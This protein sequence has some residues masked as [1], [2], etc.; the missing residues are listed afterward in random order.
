MAKATKKATAVKKESKKV[1]PKAKKVSTK[2]ESTKKVESKELEP[3]VELKKVPDTKSEVKVKKSSSK[4]SMTP[5]KSTPVVD[6]TPDVPNIKE[7]FPA[8]FSKVE[9]IVKSLCWIDQLPMANFFQVLELPKSKTRGYQYSLVVSLAHSIVNLNILRCKEGEEM[10]YF[11]GGSVSYFEGEFHFQSDLIGKI[12]TSL[13]K[14]E[15]DKR[16]LEVLS[17]AP[18]KFYIS[19]SQELLKLA[20]MLE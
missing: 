14:N 5:K 17:T 2:K 3:A 1:E 6:S 4:S 10:S 15:V 7:L 8:S 20:G 12:P 11:Y 19:K 18:S 13:F 9:Q 16:F